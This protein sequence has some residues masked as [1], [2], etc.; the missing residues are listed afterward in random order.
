MDKFIPFDKLSKREQRELMAKKRRT[1]GSIRP[2]TRKPDN[3]KAY[4]RDKAR[5]WSDDSSADVSFCFPEKRGGMKS[6]GLSRHH[7]GSCED[8]RRRHGRG[9]DRHLRA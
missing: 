1:W 9:Q 7:D 4:K 8:G 5:K 3:P 2:V 6:G